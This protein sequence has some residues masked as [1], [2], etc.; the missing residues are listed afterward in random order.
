LPVCRARS[1][2]TRGKRLNTVSMG[3]TRRSSARSCTR[4]RTEWRRWS[5]WPMRSNCSSRSSRQC[6]SSPRSAGARPPPL[7]ACSRIW[8]MRRRT[9]APV[10]SSTAMLRADRA[11]TISPIWAMK[12]SMV[13]PGTRTTAS[14]RPSSLRFSATGVDASPEA[15]FGGRRRSS[16]A[17]G[18]RRARAAATAAPSR[19]LRTRN[20]RRLLPPSRRLR[21]VRAHWPSASQATNAS[22]TSREV[23]RSASMTCAV[24]RPRAMASAASRRLAGV[25][26]ASMGSATPWATRWARAASTAAAPWGPPS[27][28]IRAWR[29]DCSAVA[30]TWASA[31]GEVRAS[32]AWIRAGRAT[33]ISSRPPST[34]RTQTSSTR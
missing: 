31:S 14:R 11:R 18:S 22:A 25:S 27:A 1:R 15:G 17:V 9:V 24:V 19:R 20:S 28:A 2:T 30:R 26:R 12:R 29:R 5:A 3:R 8:R 10:S 6:C 33:S 13:S 4:L 23:L 7:R 32:S 34:A 16:V 21:L